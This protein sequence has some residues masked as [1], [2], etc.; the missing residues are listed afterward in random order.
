VTDTDTGLGHSL[1]LQDGDL[2]LSAG[3]LA[4]V[5]GI[6]NLAQA[7]TLRVLTPYGSDMFNTRYGLSAASAFTRP[8]GLRMVKELLRL[9]LV[10][11]IGADPRVSDVRSVLFDDDPAFL[12]AHPGGA[13]DAAD[14]RL[15]RT[16]AVEV[17]IETATGTGATL[18]VDVEV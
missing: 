5:D 15:R 4:E 10:R 11:T 3:A 9:E 2:V 8:Y 12:A 6:A 1:L 7:L 16:W 17:D 18:L 13:A 14:R